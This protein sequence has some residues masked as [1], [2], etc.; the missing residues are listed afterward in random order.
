MRYFKITGTGYCRYEGGAVKIN[1]IVEWD[2][3]ANPA[4]YELQKLV[5]TCRSWDGFTTFKSQ[6]VNAKGEP[7]GLINFPLDVE[8]EVKATGYGNVFYVEGF[9]LEVGEKYRVVI[10]KIDEEG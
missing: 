5:A 4:D 1:Q 2:N 10:H 9:N 8:L 3:L 7:I 6:E